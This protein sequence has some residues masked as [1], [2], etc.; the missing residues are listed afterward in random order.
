VPEKLRDHAWFVAYAPAENPEI[1][2][3]VLVEHGGHGASVAA[4]IA[5]GILEAY[6]A[7]RGESPAVPAAA[8][9]E[10]PAPA[11]GGD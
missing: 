11:G 7:R 8:Q 5:K 4:P 6:F 2:V 10:N 1:A 9:P 3:V